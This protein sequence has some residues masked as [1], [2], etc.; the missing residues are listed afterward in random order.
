MVGFMKKLAAYREIGEFTAD[1]E[2]ETRS[3][4]LEPVRGKFYQRQYKAASAAG[5]LSARVVVNL[6]G[7]P[8]SLRVSNSLGIA[9][10]PNLVTKLD[11]NRRY[12][13]TSTFQHYAHLIT[14]V[15]SHGLH[16]VR[17]SDI[18][19]ESAEQFDLGL[20]LLFKNPS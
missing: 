4:R 11:F 1:L 7:T 2:G 15:S 17:M 14:S 6:D 18:P 16:I 9:P 20:D 3:R 19:E 8:T 12:V 10:G 13:G 5:G